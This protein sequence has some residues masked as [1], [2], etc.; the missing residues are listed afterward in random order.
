MKKLAAIF[1]VLAMAA[2]TLMRGDEMHHSMDATEKLGTVSFPISCSADVQKDFEHGVALLHSFQYSQARM[3]FDAIVAKDSDCSIARWGQAMSL[4]HQLWERP[5]GTTLKQGRE[6]LERAQKPRA[7]TQRENDYIT[8]LGV[9]Y[10]EDAKVEYQQRTVA[11]A[12]AMAKLHEKYPSDHEAAVFYGL[13]L[14]ASAPDHDTT[15]DNS[16][17]AIAILNRVYE[18]A[19]DHPGVAHYLIHA[20]DNPQLAQLGLEAARRYAQLAPASPHALHMPSHIFARLGLWQEDIQ[21][22]L[23]AIAAMQGEAHKH[24]GMEYQVH[25]MD[26]LLYA[27]LQIGE[28]AKAREV[29]AEVGP[30]R[31]SDMGPGMEGYLGAMKAEFPATYALET[32]NWEAAASLVPPTGV[33]PE[34]E[35]I[36]YWAQA[37]GAGHLKDRVGAKKAADRYDAMV[38]ATKKGPRAYVAEYMNTDREESQAW[39]TFAEGRN[40]DALRLLRKVADTQD[41]EGKG[42]VEL[43]AREMLADMLLEM[44][45]P[46]EALAEYEIS[47]KVDPNRFNGLYGAVRAAEMTQQPEKAAG[48]Y[49]RLIKNCGGTSERPELAEATKLVTKSSIAAVRPAERASRR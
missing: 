2:P 26:F 17:K 25:P 36:T 23:A 47:M 13:S 41:A 12:E 33:E 40:D 11:Y 34:D 24:M 1:F 37:V 32:R 39:L 8:A 20:S 43:P 42:E 27:Y 14:L 19:P 15:L 49:A 7:K 16:R 3:Q 10:R 45:R 4:Y 5:D 29:M 35:S 21:S 48:Y 38:E 18:E 44:G 22:N 6:M 30:M 28:D 9:F 31:E 46:G